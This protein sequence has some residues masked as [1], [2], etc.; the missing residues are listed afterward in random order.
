MQLT[1]ENL[2]G[3]DLKVLK[4]IER[5]CIENLKRKLMRIVFRDY[6]VYCI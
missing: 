1:E 4:E 3:F 6:F 5:N 2:F